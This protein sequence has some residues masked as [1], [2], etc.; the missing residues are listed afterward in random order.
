MKKHFSISL[1]LFFTLFFTNTAFADKYTETKKMFQDAG[2]SGDFFNNSYGYALFPTIAKAGFVIGGAH[3]EGR[4]YLNGKHVG[5]TKMTQASIGFQLGAQGYSQIIFF[6]DKRAFDDFTNGNF[7]FGAEAEAVVIT[8][9][10]G[11]KGTTTGSS[12]TA[13]GGKNNAETSGKYYKG[14]A[15]FTIAKGGLMYSASVAGQKFTYQS[16]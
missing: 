11:A 7:E 15:V 12:A 9:A 6:Q 3:G 13:S 14:M 16:K 10:A 1:I 5:D 4:V 2:E 8:A